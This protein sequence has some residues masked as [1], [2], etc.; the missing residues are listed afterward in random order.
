V[1]QFEVVCVTHQL[2][3]PDKLNWAGVTWIAVGSVNQRSVTYSL[4]AIL[5][6][7]TPRIGLCLQIPVS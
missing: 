4:L 2:C 3:S 7:P 5:Y 1:V 6:D